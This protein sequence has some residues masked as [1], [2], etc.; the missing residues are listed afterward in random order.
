GRINVT[1]SDIEKVLEKTAN[2]FDPAH[3]QLHVVG[4]DG[5]WDWTWPAFQPGAE[6]G[7]AEGFHQLMRTV[8]RLGCKIGLHMNVMGFSYQHP[9][10]DELKHFLQ[11]QCRD[12]AN[13][14][15]N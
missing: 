4:W 12:S 5:P 6:L 10:F 13:R 1:F 3:T 9:Q 15:L 8:H 14:P 2:Y 11:Y 7:D